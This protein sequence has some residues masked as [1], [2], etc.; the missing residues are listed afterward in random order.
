MKFRHHLVPAALAALLVSGAPAG[1][2]QYDSAYSDL[3]LDEC[4]VTKSDDFGT[5]WS[6]PGYKGIPVMVA[7][8][9]LRFFVSYGLK[10]T[11]EKAAE[12]TLPPFNYLG[13]KIE[14]RVSNAEGGFKPFATILR[15]YIDKLEQGE[16]AGQVLV[17]TRLGE[18]AT[19]HV[20][21]IDALANENANELARQTADEKAAAFDCGDEPEIVGEFTAW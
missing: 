3:N 12:Q 21:Y 10:S 8:G 4:S 19:C 9:D 6:C 11:A 17:I 20:A 13:S 15:Y 2:Q 1:A 18:G 5:T 14:W 16:K 7:E